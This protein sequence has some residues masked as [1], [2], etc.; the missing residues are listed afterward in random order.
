MAKNKE[1]VSR[2]EMIKQDIS[3]KEIAIE[4]MEE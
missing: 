2:N 4:K 1:S 3:L